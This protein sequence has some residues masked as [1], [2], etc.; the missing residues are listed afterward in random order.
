[1]RV[2]WRSSLQHYFNWI[3]VLST[4]AL[5]VQ[6]GAAQER[7]TR[8]EAERL[9]F[10]NA[11]HG[12]RTTFFDTTPAEKRTIRAAFIQSLLTEGPPGKKLNRLGL[13][14]DHASF[15]A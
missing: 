14:I 15:E 4:S 11:A 10:T 5:L 8:N 7:L 9:V 12:K 3:L 2:D 6:I 1:M 13:M